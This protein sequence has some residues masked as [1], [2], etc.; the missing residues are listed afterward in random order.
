MVEV[1]VNALRSRRHALQEI[2]LLRKILP[3]YSGYIRETSRMDIIFAPSKVKYSI[4]I[5]EPPS[6][7]LAMRNKKRVITL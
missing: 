3:S 2:I 6:T 7:F 1:F 5:R 4:S